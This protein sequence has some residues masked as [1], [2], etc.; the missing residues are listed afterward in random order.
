MLAF[1]IWCFGDEIR[2]KL[3]ALLKSRAPEGGV[4]GVERNSLT[5]AVDVELLSLARN[6]EAHIVAAEALGLKIG[7][8]RQI[9]PRAFL[10]VREV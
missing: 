5:A 8:R 1:L 9:D 4:S 3:H 6:E 10:E 2:A 7:R